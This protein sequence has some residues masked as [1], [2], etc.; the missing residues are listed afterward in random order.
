MAGDR[1]RKSTEFYESSNDQ[2]K[3]SRFDFSTGSGVKL[4]SL[5]SWVSGNRGKA[6]EILEEAL[7]PLHRAVFGRPGIKGERRAALGDY[8]GFPENEASIMKSKVTSWKKDQM[9]A[10][11][12]ALD[13]P[14]VTVSVPVADLAEGL[15]KFLRHPTTT[16][17]AAA[18][19]RSA[20]KEGKPKE[21]K[22][23]QKR[24]AADEDVADDDAPPVQKKSRTEKSP[25]N[26]ALHQDSV[27][28]EVYRRVL[29]MDSNT[30]AE[31]SL[32]ALRQEL[33]AHFGVD[34]SVIKT[35]SN[36]I[37]EAAAACV[38]ALRAAEERAAVAKQVVA[39][40]VVEA[41]AETVTAPEASAVATPA[42]VESSDAPTA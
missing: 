17:T 18:P 2:P 25:S 23:P 16:K 3:G 24:A 33:A 34:A 19:K 12:Q 13:V 27:L 29:A 42:P 32:K 28:L 14:G 7:E 41:A 40:A 30:R 36:E 20:A 26:N 37:H 22:Q 6:A 11:V 8:R 1:V 5:D 4:S 31:L 21:K 15:L 35:Y 10:L 38:H 39:P 9:K